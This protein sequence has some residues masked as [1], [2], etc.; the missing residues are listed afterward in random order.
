VN[1]RLQRRI[2]RSGWNKAVRYYES[3][4]KQQLA[5]AHTR[6]LAMADKKAVDLGIPGTDANLPPDLDDV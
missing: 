6:L 2:Q 5:V 1:A 4:W 3:C